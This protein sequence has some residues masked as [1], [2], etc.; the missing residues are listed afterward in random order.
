MG[1]RM[2]AILGLLERCDPQDEIYLSNKKEDR[3]RNPPIEQVFEVVRHA[4]R[5]F[6]NL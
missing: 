2:K 1:W 4:L 5:I 6:G 3:L